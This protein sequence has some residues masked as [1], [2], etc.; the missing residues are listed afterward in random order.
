[1]ASDGLNRTQAASENTA[2]FGNSIITTPRTAPDPNGSL[3]IAS[4]GVSEEV[5]LRSKSSASDGEMFILHSMVFGEA[6]ARFL[7]DHGCF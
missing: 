5:H 6:V 1:M 7:R 4:T 3:N 2:T